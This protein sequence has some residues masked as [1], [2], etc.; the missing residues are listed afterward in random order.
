M[1]ESQGGIR[2]KMTKP[3]SKKAKPQS[4][5]GVPP[6]KLAKALLAPLRK[7]ESKIRK[8]APRGQSSI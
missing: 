7:L 3:K 6:E 4:L 5:Y 1:S 8:S 2:T